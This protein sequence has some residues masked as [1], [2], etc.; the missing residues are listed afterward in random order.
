ML[1]HE[2]RKLK[3]LEEVEHHITIALAKINA[4]PGIYIGSLREL[5]DIIGLKLKLEQVQKRVY[6]G[7]RWEKRK[8]EKL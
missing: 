6:A 5:K 2:Q 7:H 3:A 8:S 4:Y 1:S